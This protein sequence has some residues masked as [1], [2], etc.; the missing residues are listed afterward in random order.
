MKFLYVPIDLRA[1]VA[2]KSTS[3]EEKWTHDLPIEARGSEID[4]TDPLTYTAFNRKDWSSA[5]L[6]ADRALLP[7]S[8]EL[9]GD[10]ANRSISK[11]KP[12]VPWLR[13]TVYLGGEGHNKSTGNKLIAL[14]DDAQSAL[15][16]ELQNMPSLETIKSNIELSF[17]AAQEPPVH[18]L[19]PHLTPVEVYDVFP[20]FELWP[21][22]YQE[23]VFDSDPTPSHLKV[24]KKRKRTLAVSAEDQEYM[25]QHALLK[26]FRDAMGGSFV[27]YLAPRKRQRT[28]DNNTNQA[29]SEVEYQWIR[30]YL[31]EKMHKSELLQDYVFVTR[32]DHIS[33]VP[34]NSTVF[35][36]KTKT[37]TAE[38]KAR[39][40]SKQRENEEKE[41]GEETSQQGPVEEP[42]DDDEDLNGGRERVVL[43]VQSTFSYDEQ[44]SR[45]TRLNALLTGATV[46]SK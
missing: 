25:M 20:D 46:D 24:G 19:D 13:R 41:E 5:L 31:Y 11:S 37:V 3:L 33:Y 23:V 12:V 7:T 1:H 34:I 10:K 32:D 9:G 21:N 30:E 16:R 8:A 38:E 22:T 17:Q 35:L 45:D 18:P 14:E 29:E 4:L 42:E 39:E 44:Q 40:E 36:K 27:A 15:D 2:Y 43:T 6:D 28:E 26:G